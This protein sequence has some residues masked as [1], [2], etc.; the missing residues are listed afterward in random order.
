MNLICVCSGSQEIRREEKFGKTRSEERTGLPTTI[1]DFAKDF[2][3][4]LSTDTSQHVLY[5]GIRHTITTTGPPVFAKP[6]RMPPEYLEAAK[7]EFHIMIQQGIARPSDSAWASPL[8]MVSKQQE[9][10]WRACGDYRALNAITIADRN[11]ILHILDFHSKLQGCAVFS[12]IDLVRAFHQT[13]VAVAEEDI[14]KTAITT[15]FGFFEFPS[16]NFGLCNTVQTFQ[17]FMDKVLIVTCINKVSSSR[18]TE[19]KLR[20]QHHHEAPLSHLVRHSI[21]SGP[22]KKGGSSQGVPVTDH[23]LETPDLVKGLKKSSQ[24]KLAWTQSAEATFTAI[25]TRLADTT[26]LAYPTPHAPTS[27]YMDASNDA[28][29]TVLQQEVYKPIALYSKRLEAPQ[30]KF[31]AFDRKLV[32]MHDAAKHFRHFLEGRQCHIRTD[33]KPLTTAMQQLGTN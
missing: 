33:H 26:L 21:I 14:K 5:P 12:K 19:E 22:R 18:G 24:K 29:G 30:Q 13:P 9:G 7:R 11:P 3:H 17:R 1:T 2:P 25:K 32:A 10:E 6:R 27:I 16:M 20:Y 4:L 23:S 15:P 28:I 31:S 8:H